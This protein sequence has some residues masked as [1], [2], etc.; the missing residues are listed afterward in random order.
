MRAWS[1]YKREG[2][3]ERRRDREEK[4]G[5]AVLGGVVRGLFSVARYKRWAKGDA[6]GGQLR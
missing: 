3:E 6:F 5:V 1:K 2:E 4:G